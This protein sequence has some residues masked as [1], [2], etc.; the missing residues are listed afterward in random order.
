MDAYYIQFKILQIHNV[1]IGSTV[2][3]TT[4]HAVR[5][6][7][8]TRA[9]RNDSDADRSSVPYRH[10]PVKISCYSYRNVQRAKSR[11]VPPRLVT[12]PS[13]RPGLPVSL[14]PATGSCPVR[15][16][17][18]FKGEWRYLFLHR[19]RIERPGGPCLGTRLGWR[20][21][22][23]MRG[24]VNA[25]EK[26]QGRGFEDKGGD[27]RVSKQFRLHESLPGCQGES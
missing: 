20:E 14:L 7:D 12:T 1:T 10:G 6:R 26:G 13:A 23:D 18:E 24:Q 11:Y 27:K 21:V 5:W 19:P 22:A 3:W 25:S 4:K 2:G 9:E 15:R 17:R 8:G 16:S